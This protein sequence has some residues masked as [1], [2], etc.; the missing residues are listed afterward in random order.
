MLHGVQEGGKLQLRTMYLVPMIGRVVML[1]EWEIIQGIL[2][3]WT[4]PPR[5]I[6]LEQLKQV[7]GIQKA[8][9]ILL[10]G[11]ARIE[12]NH[13]PL[14]IVSKHRHFLEAPIS[15]QGLPLGTI[16]LMTGN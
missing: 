12:G 6:P 10:D 16:Q 4:I 8:E 5:S 11:L 15:S 3:C 1:W 2:R 7:M 9:P 13:H 14:D